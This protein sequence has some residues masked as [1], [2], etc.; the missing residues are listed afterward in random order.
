MGWRGKQVS[1]NGGAALRNSIVALSTPDV[2]MF[3]IAVG[4]DVITRQGQ[5]LVGRPP[6]HVGW[7]GFSRVT[8]VQSGGTN[9]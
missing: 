3:K 8:G 9:N 7:S 1:Q 2:R 6:A 5:I 4:T